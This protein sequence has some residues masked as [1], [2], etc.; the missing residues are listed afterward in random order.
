MRRGRTTARPENFQKR[1]LAIFAHFDCDNIVDDY[2][3][4]YLRNLNE[5][6][7]HIVFVSTAN[8]EAREREKVES[9]C[10]RV[11]CRENIGYDFY[12]YKVGLLGSA[13]K[14]E[15]YDQI[16]LCNDSVY[17]PLHSLAPMFESMEQRDIDFWGITASKQI[18]RHLQSYFCVLDRRVIESEAFKSFF[19]GVQI[20]ESKRRVIDDYEIGLSQKLEAAG[21][22]F[23]SYFNASL[24]AR[25]EV[26]KILLKQESLQPNPDLGKI[27]ARIRML[28][29]SQKLV[30]RNLR[31]AF[32]TSDFN[33]AHCCWMAMLNDE[34]PFVKI[35][36]IRNEI[37]GK[38]SAEKIIARIGS[39]S[40]YPVDLI[41][42]H[43]A[44]TSGFYRPALE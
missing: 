23:G 7:A 14:Y 11:I 15:S 26:F 37:F 43:V 31:K 1:R 12:S 24:L 44:R 38:T 34:I 21:F 3:V 35:D 5:F 33:P 30:F 9:L 42:R 39:R 22:H 29:R 27:W 10:V 8:L 6:G 32:V 16:I 25:A 17:A 28:A 4:R 20:L 36:I 13:I 2:V 18:A 40:D 41:R 19:H